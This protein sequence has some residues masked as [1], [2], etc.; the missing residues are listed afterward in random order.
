MLYAM[1]EAAYYATT[2]WRLAARAARDFWSSPINPAAETRTGRTL[3]AAADLFANVTR[4][5]GK[6]EW[7]IDRTVINGREVRVRPTTVWSSPWCK[8]VQFDRDM[9]DMRNAGVFSL[10]PAVLIVAPLSGHY[11]TLLRGTVEAFIPDHAVFVTDWSNARDVPMLDGRFDFHDY[12]DHIRT[13]LGVIGA[14][15][16]VVAVCQPGPPVLAAAS[17][18]AEDGDPAR[19]A[20]MTFMGSPIDARLSPTVTNKLAEARPFTWFQKQMIYTVPPPYPGALRRVYPGFVQLYSFMSMNAERHQ[21]AHERYFQDLV[22]GDGDSADKHLEFYDEYLSVLDMTE[23][24]YLQTIDLV[25]Q[26][27]ALPKGELEHRG[28]PVRPEAI[29]DIGLMTV[30]GENDDIS[31]IGQ[32]QAAHGLCANI[33]AALKEDY[34]QPKVGHYGVFNGRRFREEIYPRVRDFIRRTDGPAR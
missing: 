30:E 23:E 5:Y 32:T 16:H 19:P 1:H 33:P 21:E 4:R 17:L 10:D 34:I 15:A 20:S 31:G 12:I 29:I 24:F 9:A 14:R 11:A 28:R 27:Y 22:Q 25:F 6:P 13:M 7:N 2:P 26:R 18:M 3:F 8:L